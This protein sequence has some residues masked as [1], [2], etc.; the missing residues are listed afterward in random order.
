MQRN[1]KIDDFWPTR[2][3]KWGD[4]D[5]K[6]SNFP[7]KKPRSRPGDNSTPIPIVSEG[8]FVLTELPQG[9]AV[10]GLV[11]GRKEFAIFKIYK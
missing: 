8:V 10:A 7:R 5:Q 2:P 9:T 11:A 4:S 3:K 6:M 1:A